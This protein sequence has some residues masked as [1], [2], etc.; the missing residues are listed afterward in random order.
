MRKFRDKHPKR[1]YSDTAKT[2]YSEYRMELRVDFNERCAYTDSLDIWWAD[3]FHIDHFAPKK[4]KIVD[5]VKLQKFTALEH[6]YTNLIYANPQ[7]NRA[8]SND[9]PS[10]DPT[11]SILDDKGY[12]DPVAVD[13][14]EY[15]ERTN[16][17][18]IFP[19]NDPIAKYMWKRLKLYLKRYELYW[20]IEQIIIRLEKL[21]ELKGKMDLPPA[22]KTELL[23]SIA[24]LTEEHLKYL[25]YLKVNYTE[26]TRGTAK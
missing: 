9:W 13:Y 22:A 5:P 2:H 7:V 25:K 12:L 17:G 20:R 15:F 18:G 11:I 1:T 6:S 23:E 10:D 14:N 3:G 26:V 24:E 21:I 8:K 19:K 16:A 4:P